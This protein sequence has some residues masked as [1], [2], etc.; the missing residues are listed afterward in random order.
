MTW[1]LTDQGV[2]LEEVQRVQMFKYR[3]DAIDAYNKALDNHD[4][5]FKN[6][7]HD[8][9]KGEEFYSLYYKNEASPVNA[10]VHLCKKAIES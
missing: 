6:Q 9:Q 2:D 8:F 5:H 1:I 10:I 7:A 3:N 4:K